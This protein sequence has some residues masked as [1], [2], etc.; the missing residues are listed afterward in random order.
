MSYLTGY[1]RAQTNNLAGDIHVL[2]AKI[3]ELRALRVEDA[4]EIADLNFTVDQWRLHHASEKALRISMME[5][6]DRIHGSERNPFRKQAYKDPDIM[7]IPSGDRRGEVVTKAD[8]IYISKFADAFKKIASKYPH[9]S[10]WK[11]FLHVNVSY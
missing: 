6:L 5:E 1:L 2:N 9:I 10:N 3:R 8:H 11:K 7:R 4:Q